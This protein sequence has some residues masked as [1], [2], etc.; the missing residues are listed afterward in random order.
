[1]IDPENIT[2]QAIQAFL[3]AV[4]APTIQEFKIKLERVADLL[5]YEKGR[6]LT[7][8]EALYLQ[9]MAID[10]VLDVLNYRVEG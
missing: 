3:E 7:D 6:P 1:M 9:Q 4:S 8:D 5:H 10:K 2:A